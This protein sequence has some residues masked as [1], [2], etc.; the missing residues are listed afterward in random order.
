MVT[1]LAQQNP[2]LKEDERVTY[3]GYG[4]YQMCQRGKELSV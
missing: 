1:V 2:L 3:S 4:R